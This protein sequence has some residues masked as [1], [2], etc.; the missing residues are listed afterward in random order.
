MYTYKIYIFI[1]MYKIIYI[2]IY[3]SIYE[4]SKINYEANVQGV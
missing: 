3:I 1:N 2:Y 4:L